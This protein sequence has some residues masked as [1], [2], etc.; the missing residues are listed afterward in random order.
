MLMYIIYNIASKL[1]ILVIPLY[2]ATLFGTPRNFISLIDITHRCSTGA[3][4]TSYR[5][6]N[7]NA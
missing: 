3:T 5:M 6:C 4:D 7:I 1:M 2:R